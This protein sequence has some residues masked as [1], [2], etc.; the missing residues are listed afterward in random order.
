MKQNSCI[1]TGA[2][3]ALLLAAC[4]NSSAPKQFTQQHIDA[5][6]SCP[7]PLNSA[8]TATLKPEAGTFLPTRSNTGPQHPSIAEMAWI[9]GGEFSMGCGNPVGMQSGGHETMKD[10]RPVHRVY[11]K[12]F[13]MDETEVTNKQ[14][15]AFVLATGYITIAEKKPDRSEFPD[16]PE[17]N[18]V[19]GSIVFTPPSGKVA[20]EDFYQWWSYVPGA[21]WRHPL[22]PS[23]SI[24]GKENYP[25]VHVAWPDAQAYA[26]WAGKRLPTEAE[27]EFAARGGVTGALYTWGDSLNPGKKAM[28][29]TF[30]GSFPDYD[31]GND[32][33]KGIAPV[34]HYQPNGYGLYDMAGN[35]WEWCNDWYGEDYYTQLSASGVAR[36]PSGPAHASDK[37]APGN[38]EKVQRGGSF[39][40]T[41]QYCT[42]YMVGSR[43][44]GDINSASNHIGFRCVKD[45]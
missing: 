15:A 39:L 5:A 32:G 13:Y 42:R 36:N 8:A 43:G 7:N 34:K 38:K 17:E 33:Y 6:I 30:Q 4:H 9:P 26:R 1:L 21:D 18:L 27:W 14:F 37:A 41:D 10:A 20:L 16:A 22:G 3:S 24:E 45:L 31:A 44:K 12:G 25:V 28:A 23:S 40:C 29:N 11:V 19:A 35:V 2:L